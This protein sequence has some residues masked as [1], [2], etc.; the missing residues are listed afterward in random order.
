MTTPSPVFIYG[1]STASGIVGIQLAKLSGYKVITTASPRNF[2]YL[3]SLG[4]DAVFDYRSPTVVQDVAA[5]A[6]G[7]L[8]V[9][10]DC[11]SEGESFKIAAGAFSP[12]GGKLGTLLPVDVEAVH[13]INPNIEVAVTLAYTIMGQAFERYGS[14]SPP[15]PED[16]KFAKEWRDLVEPLFREG[17]VKPVKVEVNRG[18]SG[19][20]GVLVGLDEVRLNKVSGGKLI[21]TL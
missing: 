9:A 21:Y 13:A 15:K 16:N 7:E 6:G 3:K 12:K 11:I 20:E 14:Y 5:A 17:K 1:G 10:W 19:L 4:A 18:G 2:D 8:T